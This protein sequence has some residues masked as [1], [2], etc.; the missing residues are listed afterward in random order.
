M[1]HTGRRD[2]FHHGGGFLQLPDRD[3]EQGTA[4]RPGEAT[5]L[6]SMQESERRL[7]SIMSTVPDDLVVSRKSDINLSCQQMQ[8]CISLPILTLCRAAYIL[9]PSCSAYECTKG[10]CVS[11]VSGIHAQLCQHSRRGLERCLHS[12]RLKSALAEAKVHNCCDTVESTF[13][14]L[15]SMSDR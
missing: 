9:G 1:L 5:A 12:R 6:P 4:A 2:E 10:N 8:I 15:A 13:A 7:V 14:S 11:A 3:T